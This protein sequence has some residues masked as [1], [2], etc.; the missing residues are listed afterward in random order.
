M[1]L[2]DIE[3]IVTTISN[4]AGTPVRIYQDKEEIF[5]RSLVELPKDPILP[6][7]SSIQKIEKPIGYFITP[8]FFYYGFVR[9]DDYQIVLGPSRQGRN[10]E[11]DLRK[12]AFDCDIS[13][14]DTN[15]FLSSMNALVNMPLNSFLEMLCAIHFALNHQKVYLADLAIYDEEQESLSKEMERKEEIPLAMEENP[16][17]EEHNTLA[18]E[19]TILTYV[20]HGGVAAFQEWL[21]KAPA[22]HAGTLANS[23]LRQWKNTF[24]VTATLVSRSAI[25]GGMDSNDALSLSDS[26]I[27]RCEL[28]DS[29]D[30]LQNL[31]FHMLLD[32]TE[33]VEKL[34]LGKSPSKLTKEIANYVQ[35]H[36]HE[37]IDI[38]ELSQ[39]VYMSRCHLATRFKKETGMTLTE[40]ILKEKIDEAKC[41]L[42]YTDKPLSSIG[43][44][45]GFSSQSHFSNVF[46]K[47]TGE[48]PKE[49][50]NKHS[51]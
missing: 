15:L 51:K 39:A 35:K 41:L 40:Y 10:N 5:Y 42:R 38:E 6:Y 11:N 44:Y 50:R 45:L 22:T 9:H 46:R 8:S 28:L 29:V 34:R 13:N 2:E 30:R 47:L 19:Q 48:S 7:L 12:L 33:R 14:E 25:R 21:K 20:R 32:Y 24:I 36:I 37:P 3:Y 17:V 26:Y 18:V 27:Q 43:G 1:N 16:I 4:L 49:Y 23:A 31:Q